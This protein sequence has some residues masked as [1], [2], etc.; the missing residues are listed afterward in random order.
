LA[1]FNPETRV[2]DTQL[3]SNLGDSRG[4]GPNQSFEALFSGIGDAVTA[5]VTSADTFVQNKIEDDARYGFEST[6]DEMNLTPDTMPVELARSSKGLEGLR[7]AHLQGKVTQEYYHGRLAATLKGLRTR[8]PGYEKQV[9][10]IVQNVTGERPANAYRD[11][12]FANVEA[13]NQAIA[14]TANKWDQWTS[15]KENSEVLG[16]LF[17]DYFT[18]QEKYASDEAKANI[19]S[20]VSQYQGRTRIAED[21]V[22]LQ[23]ADKTV[24]KPQVGKLF[25]TVVNAHIVGGSEAAGIDQ[26][27]VQSMMTKAL[28]DGK[29]DQ[30]EK[31][32]LIGVLAQ[33]RA[34]ATS[35][36]RKRAANASWGSNFTAGEINEEVKNAMAP[37]D[38]MEAMITSDNLSGAAQVAARNKALTDQATADIYQKFPEVL[39]A[40]ALKNVSQVGA[41]TLINEVIEKNGGGMSFLNKTLGKD[42]SSAVTGGQM[43]M[44]KVVDAVTGASGKTGKEKEQLL[45]SVLDSSIAVIAAPTADQSIV[46]QT[47]QNVYGDDLDSVWK[48]VDDST[49]AKGLS[50]RARLYNKMFNPTITKQ[51][52]ALG[53]AQALQTYTAAALDKFQQIPEFRRAGSTLNEAI[54][55]N[56]YARVSYDTEKNRLVVQVNKEAL[57]NQGFFQRADQN[58]WKGELVK[59]VDA[60]NQALTTMAPIIEANGGDETEGVQNLAKQLALNLQ[61]EHKEGFFWYM[62]D[63]LSALGAPA[64]QAESDRKT[65]TDPDQTGTWEDIGAG[66][67]AGGRVQD[68]P[69]DLVGDTLK[70]NYA[71]EGAPTSD[72]AATQ[73]IANQT[74]PSNWENI[75]AE[76]TA[77]L[78]QGDISFMMK[79]G[80]NLKQAA[81]GSFTGDA[82]KFIGETDPMKIASS[83]SGLTE[84]K[85][86]KVIASFIK[87]A[88]GIDINPADTAWCAAFVNGV[89]GASGGTGTGKLNARSFLNWG[90]PV[91]KP[92]QGDVVVFERGSAASGKG[93]V[94][95]FIGTEMKDGKQYI[96]VLGGNQSDSVKE[97]SYPADKLLGYRRANS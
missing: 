49:G 94:G 75:G 74:D 86:A 54:E 24:A 38:E 91:T 88:S 5:G 37:L 72:T 90:V 40:G 92:S 18:N 46:K 1:E 63:A 57:G 66:N 42:F 31:E 39:T 84:T 26:P 13:Q 47:V 65:K 29:V 58:S 61:G 79:D 27:N 81:S 7:N 45:S 20:Q 11:A 14:S 48:V 52:T 16:V 15:Q 32:G 70:S 12:L 8:Y 93:H 89:L 9:D 56:K 62:N 28:A 87:K 68:Q 59:G 73:A 43:T 4:T 41:D 2:S 64:N 60:F 83:F 25:G 23:N 97:S 44:T 33:I 85:D 36:I 21:V 30:N 77:D 17:P 67:A 71:P 80:E 96:K 35:D 3:Q 51:I 78:P 76:Q 6:N 10:A 19:K 53:D 95:F 82:S 34:S 69:G 50:Q 55:W 22:K